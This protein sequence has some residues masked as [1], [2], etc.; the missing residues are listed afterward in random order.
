MFVIDTVGSM[1]VGHALYTYHVLNFGKNPIL[2]LEIPWSFSAE[3]FLVTLTT[4]VAQMFYANMIWKA[5]VNKITSW[6]I[7]FLALT[8]FALGIVTTVFLF[9]N[10]L[11]V[12]GTR[13]F[14]II[15]GLVQGLAAFNDVLI[16]ASLCFY[17]R[18][19]R[20]GLPSTNLLVDTLMV[21]AVSRGVLTA[22]GQILFLITNVGFPGATYYLPFHQVVGKLYVN[23]VLATLN[24]RSTFS[25]NS[26]VNVGTTPSFKF[27]DSA[28]SG[29]RPIT[30]APTMAT[31]PT[32]NTGSSFPESGDTSTKHEEIFP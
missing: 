12:V 7:I 22:I 21:Y 11:S 32:T 6:I 13:K 31:A 30:F 20:G 23:S 27:N 9:D 18:R 8:A 4:L 25:Q 3:K 19:S 14:A 15:S 10:S 29:G 5:T 26:E 16:T 2:N 28:Q 17:L 24:V 1:F